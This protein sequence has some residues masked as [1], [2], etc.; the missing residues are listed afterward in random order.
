MAD[1]LAAAA[2]AESS[3]KRA[4]PIVCTPPQPGECAQ[5]PKKRGRVAAAV[6][7]GA[8][9][10][11]EGGCAAVAAPLPGAAGFEREL[12]QCATAWLR[13]T[14][15]A[16]SPALRAELAKT[17]KRGAQ[18]VAR[19][20]RLSRLDLDDARVR[21]DLQAVLGRVDLADDAIFATVFDS[22]RRKQWCAAQAQT[23]GSLDATHGDDIAALVRW[24]LDG[25]A[26]AQGQ[27]HKGWRKSG[28]GIW[29]NLHGL[30]WALR[31]ALPVLQRVLAPVADVRGLPTV[32]FK[33]P[34][35]ETLAAHNDSASWAQLFE[36]TA[37]YATVR[38]WVAGEGVQA[39]LHARGAGPTEQGRTCLLGPMTV[40]R[41]RTLLM[42]VHP[43]HP[44][45]DMPQPQ[46]G[47]TTAEPVRVSAGIAG[48]NK[49]GASEWERA[50]AAWEAAEAEVEAKAAAAAP[51]AGKF[52]AK[53]LECGGPVFYKWD[54][55]PVLAVANRVL[56]YCEAPP[57]DRAS[58]A[59]QRLSQ[60]DRGWLGQVEKAGRLASICAGTGGAEG[61][62]EPLS[63]RPICPA[64]TA[65]AGSGAYVA[66][67]PLGFIHAAEK[68]TDAA[69]LTLC[70]AICRPV[71]G[72][73][74]PL[75]QRSAQRLAALAR[76]DTE[77]V[78]RD[79]QP[80]A[81]GAVHRHPE[82]EVELLRFFGGMYLKDDEAELAL[83]QRAVLPE[84]GGP[85]P[86]LA[87]GVADS[88]AG[89]AATAGEGAA[90]AAV[91]A[92]GAVAA[93]GAAG[94]EGEAAARPQHIRF[95]E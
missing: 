44:H 61:A 91:V 95:D 36:L 24:G 88:G 90:P 10:Q 42:L 49:P 70:P 78:L 35:G 45:P 4:A 8:L 59:Q 28:F 9:D 40:A 79:R 32:I 21:G 65:A 55:A 85:P 80:Y 66:V 25:A 37:K 76:G 64:A 30:R 92:A 27:P 63:M 73:D 54:S 22:A 48:A 16:A 17:S 34:H 67:W 52:G 23:T 26:N 60:H 68:T 11:F 86:Q 56:A 87:G 14:L 7:G 82:C 77:W 75:L 53:W 39:L 13:A 74:L 58:F 43:E 46:V 94:G 15:D 5:R 31:E 84:G 62:R 71:G 69:R 33:P 18:R 29:T 81:G 1:G 57:A 41:L 20:P 38:E 19:F 50:E 6:I 47:T 89:G 72:H 93:A 12:R 2:T 83:A 3:S 51:N